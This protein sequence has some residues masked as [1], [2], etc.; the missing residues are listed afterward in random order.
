MDP[1]SRRCRLPDS[2]PQH[3]AQVSASLAASRVLTFLDR[4]FFFWKQKKSSKTCANGDSNFLRYGMSPSECDRSRARAR[5][6]ANFNN[7]RKLI[8]CE[9]VRASCDVNDGKRAAI[10]PCL[11]RGSTITA[12]DEFFRFRENDFHSIN[13]LIF[14]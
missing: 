2:C 3:A 10:E 14:C 5:G 11:A 12:G 1:V 4:R 7:L 6:K 13:Y 9:T 8:S